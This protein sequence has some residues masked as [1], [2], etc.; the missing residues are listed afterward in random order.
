MIT[1]FP[2]TLAL[3]PRTSVFCASTRRLMMNAAG[4]PRSFASDSTHFARRGRALHRRVAEPRNDHRQRV[5]AVFDRR[6]RN[7]EEFE[8]C[9]IGSRSADQDDIAVFDVV[10]ETQ[11]SL[12][13][14][15][16]LALDPA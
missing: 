9:F 1:G 13:V 2:S 8:R 14:R 11:I 3:T 15:K 5:R 10:F 16:V 6:G 4:T 7:V 12:A